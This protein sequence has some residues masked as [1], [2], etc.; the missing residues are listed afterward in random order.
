[1]RVLG[2]R[3]GRWKDHAAN[4]VGSGGNGRTEGDW[5]IRERSSGWCRSLRRRSRER[6]GVSVS[7]KAWMKGRQGGGTTRKEGRDEPFG[8]LVCHRQRS[9]QASSRPLDAVKP[10]S[11]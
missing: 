5:R 7:E 6:S 2:E 8:L 1:M 4:R 9:V 10:S 11:A 3:M